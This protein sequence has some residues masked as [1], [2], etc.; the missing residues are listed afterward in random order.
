MAIK[1]KAV[2]KQRPSHTGK[3][4]KKA[5]P[6]KEQDKKA[7]PVA[8]PT[9]ARTRTVMS[10][11]TMRTLNA[12]P[13]VPPVPVAVVK[14]AQKDALVERFRAEMPET[15]AERWDYAEA[16]Y[17]NTAEKMFQTG[18]VLVTLQAET[19][20]GAFEDELERR[21]FNPRTARRLMGVSRNFA[22]NYDTVK[23]LGPAKLY[24]IVEAGMS[25]DDIDPEKNTIG[26]RAVDDVDKLSAAAAKEELRK[27]KTRISKLS[28]QNA[29]AETKI[30]ELDAIARPMPGNFKAAIKITSMIKTA[31]IPAL[32]SIV[33]MDLENETDPRV[34]Q[35]IGGTLAL[36]MGACYEMLNKIVYESPAAQADHGAGIRV[37]VGEEFNALRRQLGIP[38]HD[39]SVVSG[40]GETFPFNTLPP[41]EEMEETN[42]A[43]DAL[44]N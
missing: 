38:D 33:N 17:K 3:L 12:P 2:G 28:E 22:K 39:D 37:H 4:K 9:P 16:L 5:E 1:N 25:D 18:I 26:G 8:E 41:V 23:K 11:V 32:R 34:V 24:A 29:A 27:A 7:E 44:D 30:A 19:P 35:E 36:M 43:N 15:V 6:K 10:P 31:C 13:P 40:T 20:Y 42:A 14:H 21:G